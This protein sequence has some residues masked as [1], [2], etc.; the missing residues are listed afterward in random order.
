MNDSDTKEILKEFISSPPVNANGASNS[1]P[2]STATALAVELDTARMY[3]S[4][5]RVLGRCV[6]GVS[7]YWISRGVRAELGINAS[8]PRHL[9]VCV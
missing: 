2:N 4:A 5:E 3:L 7:F 1:S 6:F 9:C 8:K